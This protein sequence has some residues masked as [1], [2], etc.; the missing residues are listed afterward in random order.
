M[1]T[2]ACQGALL[3]SVMSVSRCAAQ[4][5]PDAYA[6]RSG[7]IWYVTSPS[8]TTLPHEPG[9]CYRSTIVRADGVAAMSTRRVRNRPRA[10]PTRTERERLSRRT[11]TR[12]RPSAPDTA[13]LIC[14][15]ALAGPGK[16]K[17]GLTP[18]FGFPS[19]FHNLSANG[20]SIVIRLGAYDQPPLRGPGG[21]LV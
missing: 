18:S 7:P 4:A 10:A 9:R 8:T 5:S 1:K 6:F 13:D 19:L 15:D 16:C 17:A 11:E 2:R 14:R 21:M 12:P 20:G 3:S